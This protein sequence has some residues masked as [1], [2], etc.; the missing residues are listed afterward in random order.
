MVRLIFSLFCLWFVGSIQFNIFPSDSQPET[1]Q[2]DNFLSFPS[3]KLK[4]LIDEYS[5]VVAECELQRQLRVGVQPRSRYSSCSPFTVLFMEMC[6][7]NRPL[8]LHAW[9]F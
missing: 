5:S 1:V 4:R 7:G 8:C 6:G 3:A 9:G 2:T